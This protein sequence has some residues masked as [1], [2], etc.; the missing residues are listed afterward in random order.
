MS[1][2]Y[3]DNQVFENI[4]FRLNPLPIGEYSDCQFSKCSFENCNL[5]GITFADCEFTECDMSN[6]ILG[7][8]SFKTVLF[9]GCKMFGLQFNN[10]REFLLEMNFIQCTLNYSTLHGLNL[11]KTLFKHC[12]CL[13]V[14]FDG[15]NLSRAVFEE[16]NLKGAIFNN[17]N[18]TQANLTTANNFSINPANN[19]LK[20]ASFSRFNISGLVNHLDINLK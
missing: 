3:I 12:D 20:K 17:T 10:C 4:D 16:T 14:D 8:T 19:I 9:R 18:L 13:E 11:T 5:S 7:D 6:A 1:K 2:E 15:A